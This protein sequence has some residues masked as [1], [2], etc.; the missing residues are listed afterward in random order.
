MQFT[1]DTPLV[2]LDK[3]SQARLTAA[4]KEALVIEESVSHQDKK[5]FSKQ[6]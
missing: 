3:I 6:Q 1:L 2:N 5:H 4:Q